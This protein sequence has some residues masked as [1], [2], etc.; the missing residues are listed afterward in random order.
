M[1]KDLPKPF[2]GAVFYEDSLVY[3]ALA[4]YPI[5]PGHAVVVWKKRVKDVHLLSRSEYEHLMDVV[6][7]VRSAMLKVLRLKKIYLLYLDEVLHVHWHL[8]PRYHKQGFT[9]L[10]EKPGK[11]TDFSLVLKLKQ[12]MTRRK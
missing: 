11:L 4:N 5:T 10:E 8:I 3:A 6:D 12:E 1:S 7:R 2:N 9:V